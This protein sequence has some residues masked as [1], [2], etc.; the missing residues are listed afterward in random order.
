MVPYPSSFYPVEGYSPV[1]LEVL[2]LIK[3]AMTKET[4]GSEHVRGEERGK[5]RRRRMILERVVASRELGQK[6]Q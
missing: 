2:L 3:S 1:T 6:V 4:G 5:T